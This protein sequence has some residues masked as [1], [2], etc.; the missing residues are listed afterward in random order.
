MPNW[1]ECDLVVEGPEA[2]LAKFVEA[3]REKNPAEGEQPD[4][5]SAASFIPYP[6]K[7]RDIDEAAAKWEAEYGGK[8]DTDW[9]QRPKDGFNSGG[10]EWCIQ[11]W[12]TK[13]GICRPTVTDESPT[14]MA[15]TFECAW[16]PCTP[17][18]EKMGRMFPK[19]R[20]VLNYYEGGMGFQGELVVEKGKVIRD[21]NG[22]YTGRRGG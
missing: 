13:W 17:V 1:C 15:Y 9:Q 7:F 11:H 8:P 16:G 3:A 12:G 20:F 14:L 10:Y 19:L 5:L 4:V 6:K 21:M 22:E 18:I 2:D